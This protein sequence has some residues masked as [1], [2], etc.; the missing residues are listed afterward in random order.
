MKSKTERPMVSVGLIIN[1][2]VEQGFDR[3]SLKVGNNCLILNTGNASIKIAE[4]YNG[5]VDLN[6]VSQWFNIN[7]EA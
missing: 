6:H 7:H 3:E 4:I 5:E 1:G 2:L